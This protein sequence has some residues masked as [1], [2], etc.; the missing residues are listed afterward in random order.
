MTANLIPIVYRL[1][2]ARIRSDENS[3]HVES[4]ENVKQRFFPILKDF[5]KK[6]STG[7]KAQKSLTCLVWLFDLCMY[8]FFI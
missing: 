8:L 7:S 3:K 1:T 2:I 4:D 5:Q 6:D